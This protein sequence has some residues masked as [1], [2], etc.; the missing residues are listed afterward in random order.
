NRW[1]YSGDKGSEW[2]EA[3]INASSL[4]AIMAS[5]DATNHRFDCFAFTL[6]IAPG[7]AHSPVNGCAGAVAL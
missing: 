1:R 2:W 7:I 5:G 3:E 6:L 4:P